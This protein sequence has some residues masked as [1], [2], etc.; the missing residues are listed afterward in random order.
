MKQN[1]TESGI[2]RRLFLGTV[3]MASTGNA[4][5]PNAAEPESGVPETG[6]VSSGSSAAY[7]HPYHQT[8][9][10]KIF[11]A[12][13]TEPRALLTTDD[14]LEVIRK[15]HNLTQGIPTIAYLVGWQ[16]EGHD[17]KYPAWFEVNRKIKG[18]EDA[19]AKSSLL[20]LMREARRYSTVV[21]THINMCDAYE[22]SPLWEEYRK[23]DLLI[24]EADGSLT[25]GGIWDGEQ[26]YLVCKVREWE[27]GLARR[28]IDQFL[29]M[30][31]IAETGTVHIDVFQP[32]ESPYHKITEADD[33]RGMTE[34]LKYWRS[35][36][37]DVTK[38][39]FH[40]EFAG[41]VPMAWHFNLEEQDRLQYP[42]SFACGGGSAWN[43]RAGRGSAWMGR[44]PGAGCLYPQVWGQSMYGEPEIMEDS[45]G[46]K[47]VLDEFC[48]K[49]LPWYLMNRREIQ[50]H[51]QTR[52]IYEVVFSGNLRSSVEK[53]GGRYCLKEDDRVLVDG[54]DLCVPA[55]WLEA[56]CIA[57][58]R[59]GCSRE[60]ELPPNWKGIGKADVFAV[61]IEGNR[62]VE[63]AAI[64]DRRINVTLQPGK[65]VFL[66]P[67]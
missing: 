38:E 66:V 10:I 55:L 65:A 50:E 8:L 25:K 41:L 48:L 39:Y 27:S 63:T 5:F 67:A 6:G 36:G 11:M 64:R 52:D 58:S 32:N 20:R 37:V 56:G 34:I 28:R 23:K 3:A 4:S 47:G 14:T 44:R 35:R 46:L 33:A 9:V 22:N 45:Q 18:P 13:K 49:T 61:E 19:D 12:R 17:S 30:L 62:L 40:H 51:R 7:R 53:N 15:L 59:S 42:A 43:S 31:P 57:Y 60:W 1:R 24:R 29:E 16:Y 21:S 54:N 26:S 2:N